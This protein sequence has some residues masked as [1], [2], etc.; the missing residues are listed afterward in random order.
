MP[1]P[2]PRP[3]RILY[4]CHDNPRPAGGVRAIYRQV[5]TLRRHGFD[6]V[7]MHR[8]T[9]FKIDWFD[10]GDVPVLYLNDRHMLARRDVVVIPED[11]RS[12][13]TYFARFPARRVVFC[14]N[15]YYGMYQIGRHADWRQYGI[16]TVLCSSVAIRD[17]MEAHYGYRDLPV[18]PYHIDPTLFRPRRK[19]PMIAYLPRKR[20]IEA[21]LIHLRFRERFPHLAAT[22]FRRLDN[23]PEGRVAQVFG[24]CA[25]VLMLG[26][27]EGLGLPPLEAMSAGA[28]AVGYHGDGGREFAT[29]ENGLWV[30]DGDIEGCVTALGRA[31]DAWHVGD[32][33]L[34]RLRSA[35]FATAARYSLAAADA[36]LIGFWE[37]MAPGR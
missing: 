1:A 29:D 19:L 7:V 37:R 12:G 32:P 20:Q 16:E 11:H 4:L 30:E 6:A 27:F 25:I 33:M 8:R 34:S 18:V 3:W 23:A 15:H 24:E 35:G 21:A 31:M 9:G 14:Q 2:S 36:A 22:P 28:I 5:A 17:F 26:R 10:T 13:L